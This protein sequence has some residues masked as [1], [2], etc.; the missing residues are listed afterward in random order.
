MLFPT[1]ARRNLAAAHS[2]PFQR[3]APTVALRIVREP[4][5]AQDVAQSVFIQ[6]ARKARSVRDGNALPGW[7]YRVTC[8]ISKDFIR[9]EHRRR[10]RETEAMN[11]IATNSAD[12]GAWQTL[13]P[14]L[15]EAVQQLNRVD[16]S[17]VVLRFM[18]GK[19][20]R[21]LEAEAIVAP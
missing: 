19:S 3:P 16:Q 2:L 10:E 1:G 20:L 6:M 15:D 13:A 5:L 11:R 14:F 9:G 4:Q 17:A 21:E 7:L 8:S 18:E 12:E